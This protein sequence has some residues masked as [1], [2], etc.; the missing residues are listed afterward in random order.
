MRADEIR[1]I[2]GA[3]FLTAD[4]DVD[5][6]AGFAADLMS[7]V[8]R[9]GRPNSLLVTGLA[10]P[11][12][13]YTAEMVDISVICFVRGKTPDAETV[14]LATSRGITLMSTPLLMFESCGR[15]YAHGLKS[16]PLA[17]E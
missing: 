3:R 12:V 17:R 4:A 13:I 11:S 9:L 10:A 5:V 2:L 15:L 14:R 16:A 6:Q 1:T 7:D 8:L